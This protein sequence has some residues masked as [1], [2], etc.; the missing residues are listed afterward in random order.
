M[1]A[2]VPVGQ[3]WLRWHV[4]SEF[5]HIARLISVL[6]GVCNL[7]KLGLLVTLEHLQLRIHP[8]NQLL[9]LLIQRTPILVCQLILMVVDLKSP[10]VNLEHLVRLITL[11]AH[12]RNIRF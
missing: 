7:H 6:E 12:A 11:E 3:R 9:L 2:A 5:W 10:L 4:L 8:I 1:I